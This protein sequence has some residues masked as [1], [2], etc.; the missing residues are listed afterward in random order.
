MIEIYKLSEENNLEKFM[1]FTGALA[2]S[3]IAG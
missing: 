3:S 2:C 1:Q